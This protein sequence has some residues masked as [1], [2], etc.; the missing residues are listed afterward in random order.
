MKGYVVVHMPESVITDR[1]YTTF[2]TNYITLLIILVLNS[3]FIIL[4]IIHIHNPL[5]DITNA[6]KEYGRGN[7]SYKVAVG[8]NDEIGQLSASLNYMATQIN[9]MDQFQQKFLS[10]ISHDFRSPLTSIKG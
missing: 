2:N 8:H 1:V 4:Y 9:E 6:I 10:N 7:L 3:A 5:K